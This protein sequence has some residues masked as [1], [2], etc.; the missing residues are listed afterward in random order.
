[1]I[2]VDG[3]TKWHDHTYNVKDIREV[4]STINIIKKL[5]FGDWSSNTH[6]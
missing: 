6:N 2:V 5:V 4:L 1:M 3:Q